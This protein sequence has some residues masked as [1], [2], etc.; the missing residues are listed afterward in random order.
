MSRYVRLCV[1]LAGVAPLLF[2]SGCLPTTEG[3]SDP[4][5]AEVDDGLCGVWVMKDGDET[6]VL[7]VGRSKAEG[8]PPGLME[9]ATVSY[10]SRFKTAERPKVNFFFVSKVGDQTYANVLA[11][12]A[13]P[14][15][16]EKRGD[17]ATW[18]R[19]KDRR[20]VIFR[21][22]VKKDSLTVW[23]FPW[24]ERAA[25]AKAQKWEQ[26]AGFLE[27][28]RASLRAYLA[29]SRGKDFEKKGRKD[30]YSRLK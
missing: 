26:D 4:A 14:P 8:T 24:E 18:Q 27:A 6:A 1:A 16:L 7:T 9:A 30:V 2:A 23:F 11:G 10:S 22:E 12:K 21:Y 29:R 15:V 3:L 20:F 13:K 5:K 17:F 25:L 28:D 19:G